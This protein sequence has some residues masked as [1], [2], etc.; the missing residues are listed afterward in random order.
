MIIL[1]NTLVTSTLTVLALSVANTFGRDLAG[2]ASQGSPGRRW[3]AS[4]G[5][6]K[7]PIKTEYKDMMANKFA[8]ALY[9]WL[10]I[11]IAWMIAVIFCANVG[12][13]EART[14]MVAS[15]DFNRVNGPIG[16]NWARPI[17][18]EAFFIVTNNTVGVDTMNEHCEACWASNGF[19]DAQY[20]QALLTSI[21]P[22]TGVILQADTNHDEFYMGYVFG[23]TDYR[24][25]H[26]VAE[27][28]WEET[29]GSTETWQ[30]NDV[31]KLE[32]SDPPEP[33]ITMY[34]NGKPV[35]LWLITD[36][37]D[38]KTGGSPGICI[39]SPAGDHLTVDNWEGGNLVPDANAPTVPTN[40]VATTVSPSQINL[41]WT[42][43]TDDVGVV[44]YLV[45]RSQGAGSTNFFLLYT[46]TGTNYSDAN[47]WTR[48]TFYTTNSAS[49]SSGGTYNYRLRATDAA[50]NFSGYSEVV[51]ATTPSDLRHKR[52]VVNAGTAR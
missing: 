29:V 36:H 44:G 39:Y 12:M 27:N 30:T 22:F 4:E 7:Q 46:P 11:T 41:N 8:T 2:I 24:I 10:R 18:S 14:T 28:Y 33:L 17:T 25:Y 9:R 26:R 52:I 21:G 49:L 32:V 42:P 20:A 38:V 31:L 13:L 48:Y 37:R 5:R 47:T 6:C 1:Q 16:T 50:G 43:S 51:T 19:S 23:P 3:N 35:L 40:L 34:R 15:D 45:E